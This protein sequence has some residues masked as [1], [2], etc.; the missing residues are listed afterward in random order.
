MHN[1]PRTLEPFCYVGD[2]LYALVRLPGRMNT[3][4]LYVLL[5]AHQLLWG[6]V[7]SAAVR[8]CLMPNCTYNGAEGGHV[9]ALR[10]DDGLTL[11]LAATYDRPTAQ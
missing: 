2:L 8:L 11:C 5:Q 9:Q 3:T 10:C 7:G 1:A 4:A 6:K